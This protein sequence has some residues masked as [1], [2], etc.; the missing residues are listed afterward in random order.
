MRPRPG[1]RRL[2]A[3]AAA[4]L[5]AHAALVS[6]E[7]PGCKPHVR[8]PGR[9]AAIGGRGAVGGGRL[10][11]LIEAANDGDV[12]SVTRPL[13]AEPVSIALHSG[14]QLRG[15][16]S[17]CASPARPD[18]DRPDPLRGVELPELTAAA[19]HVSALQL[20]AP[21]RTQCGLAFLALRHRGGP[22]DQG[23]ADDGRPDSGADLG[24]A[25][26]G[27]AAAG[28]SA[29]TP[30][31]GGVAA[32]GEGVEARVLR[33]DALDPG[34]SDSAG[35]AQ[36][37]LDPAGAACCVG[38]DA[39][40]LR[41]EACSVVAS[42]GTCVGVTGGE[43]RRVYLSIYLSID[44]SIHLS[45]YR[46]IYLHIYIYREREIDRHIGRQIDG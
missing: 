39:G 45:I 41:M 46:S 11:Q 12:I 9:G 29:G 26:G 2:P 30:A 24:A 28:V 25:R 3:G 10:L 37:L 35:V 22:C 1:L 15:E 5:L 4:L 27:V 16:T 13:A 7:P 8:S 42:G 43:A 19:G 14:L 36:H 6:V 17:A 33:P 21:N 38:V 20:S 18:D 40:V 23:A 32:A 34:T 31:H 44:L